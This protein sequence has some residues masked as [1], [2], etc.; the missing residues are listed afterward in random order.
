MIMRS[1]GDHLSHDSLAVFCMIMLLNAHL[2]IKCIPCSIIPCMQYYAYQAIL[3]QYYT[4]YIPC[5]RNISLLQ[6]AYVGDIF[7]WS[8]DLTM[9]YFRMVCGIKHAPIKHDLAILLHGMRKSADI[10]LIM[11]SFGDHELFFKYALFSMQVCDILCQGMRYFLVSQAIQ[12]T[13]RHA[14][15]RMHSMR[16]SRALSRALYA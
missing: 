3:C 13:M 9:H 11:L 16:Y 5:K 2:V 4:I 14:L 1:F 6:I 8:C 15:Y 10:C 12:E 7:A